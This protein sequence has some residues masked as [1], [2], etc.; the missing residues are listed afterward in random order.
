MTSS[1]LNRRT[2]LKRTGALSLG[3]AS[4]GR[5]PA[6]AAAESPN[7]K[8]VIAVMG[9]NG[10]GMDHIAGFLAQPNTEVGYV[11]DVDSRAVEKGIAAGWKLYE[12]EALFRIVP[13]HR[14]RYRRAG[15][16]RFEAGAAFRGAFVGGE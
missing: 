13:L 11:C 4:L 5:F 1:P 16:S 6:L 9:T 14:G 3:A 10:R 7:Q 15:R 12:A 2:F 8:I